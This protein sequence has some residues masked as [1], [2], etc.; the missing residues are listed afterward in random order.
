MEFSNSKPESSPKAPI[1]FDITKSI[2]NQIGENQI[3]TVKIENLSGKAQG[4]V[5]AMVST[6]SCYDIDMDHL[7]MLK[8]R[9]KVIDNFEISPDKNMITLYWTYLKEKETKTVDL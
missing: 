9:F 7:E 2:N 8:D 6:S 4:M 1:S 3:Q 5:V